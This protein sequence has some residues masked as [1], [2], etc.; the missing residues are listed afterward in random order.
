[1]RCMIIVEQQ[2]ESNAV[3]SQDVDPFQPLLS[4]FFL[5][6][7]GRVSYNFSMRVKVMDILSLP[8]LIYLFLRVTGIQ[9][10]H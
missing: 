6:F 5:R 10:T 7:G 8:W 9:L 3:E 4:S 1:M 2:F